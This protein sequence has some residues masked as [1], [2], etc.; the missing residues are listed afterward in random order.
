MDY[1]M[2]K[3]QIEELEGEERELM[4]LL[5][6]EVSLG[7]G[8]NVF[9]EHLLFEAVSYKDFFD[10][11][12]CEESLRQEVAWAAVARAMHPDWLECF[13]RRLHSECVP[14]V[15]GVLVLKGSSGLPDISIPL[16]VDASQIEVHVFE[17]GDI[18]EYALDNIG[19]FQGEYGIGSYQLTG[20]FSLG[21]DVDRLIVVLWRYRDN[22]SRVSMK[23][24]MRSCCGCV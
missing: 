21:L 2:L 24:K 17:D 23:G 5:L 15:D 4:T 22:G 16:P 14:L 11:L 8:I 1:A 20:R 18:N 7:G 9:F 10:R 19:V 6:K 3:G 12:Y 13:Q